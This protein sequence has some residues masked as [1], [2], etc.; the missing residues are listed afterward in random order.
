MKKFRPREDKQRKGTHCDIDHATERPPWWRQWYYSQSVRV[1]ECL[2]LQQEGHAKW[3]V[4]CPIP[5]GFHFVIDVLLYVPK[6]RFEWEEKTEMRIEGG[7]CASKWRKVDSLL[8]FIFLF[9]LFSL[10][11]GCFLIYL[12][13]FMFLLSFFVRKKKMEMFWKIESF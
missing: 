7:Q 8:V 13:N 4:R 3:D 10:F 9:C 1:L 12:R 11:F 2:Q 5:S 6:W